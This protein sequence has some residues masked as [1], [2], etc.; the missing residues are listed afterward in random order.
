[1]RENFKANKMGFINVTNYCLPKD[2]NLTIILIKK[3]TITW[4]KWFVKHRPQNGFYSK[5]YEAILQ[6]SNKTDNQKGIKRLQ[7]ILY[8]IKYAGSYLAKKICSIL[9]IARE[10]YIKNP[11]KY[12]CVPTQIINLKQ[13]LYAALESK[14]SQSYLFDMMAGCKK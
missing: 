2:N 9:L 13:C 3:E 11:M 4:K 5:I 12:P 6:Y 14:A 7:Q 8:L 10:K 1:M